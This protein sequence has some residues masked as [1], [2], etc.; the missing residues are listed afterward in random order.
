MQIPGRYDVT[1]ASGK[2]QFPSVL[3]PPREHQAMDRDRPTEAVNDWR[4]QV[5]ELD[6]SHIMRI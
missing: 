6:A 5:P 1:A 3:Q 4:G 2:L